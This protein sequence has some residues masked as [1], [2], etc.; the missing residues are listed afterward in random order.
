M[1]I[2]QSKLAHL[3]WYQIGGIW[4]GATIIFMLRIYFTPRY[5]ARYK[6]PNAKGPSK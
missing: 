4:L 1:L 2:F 6:K 5:V 3:H